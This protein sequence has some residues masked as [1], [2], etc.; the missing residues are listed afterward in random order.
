MKATF[1]PSSAHGSI[2]APPS[3][4]E[5]H[6][7]MISSALSNDMSV[8]HGIC[9]SD[10]M[11]ATLDSILAMGLTT[12]WRGDTVNINEKRETIND[13]QS[14]FDDDNKPIFPCYES[15]STLRFMIP[16]ALALFGGGAF[17]CQKRLIERGVEV[18]EEV[19][20][21]DGVTI[22][23]YDEAIVALGKL[24]GGKYTLRGDVSS[25]YISGLLFALPLL[26]CD[27]QIEVL[28]PFESK[29]YVDM[30]INVLAK[31]GVEIQREGNCFYI[32][33]GQTYKGGE[34]FVDG[35]WSN[36]AFLLALNEVGGCVDVKGLDCNSL[37]GD[38]VCKDIFEKLNER[39]PVIDLAN[40]PDLAPIA[41]VVASLKNGAKFVNT[42]RLKIKESDRA[43]VM[44]EEMGKLSIDVDVREN[45]VYVHK[46]DIKTTDTALYGHNDH[47]VV[48]A[49]SVLLSHVGGSIDGV[50]AVEKSFP[51]FFDVLKEL[52][53]NCEIDY[54]PS[55]E[56]IAKL[57]GVV[58]G[59]I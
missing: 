48:M 12:N 40:C 6:R 14:K 13:K 45:E 51:N 38:K 52:G 55:D 10:D 49:L 20:K 4:S 41:F 26:D 42:R 21:Q 31:F 47:R 37:Q 30:T 17:E 32:K 54:T 18:Y 22:D 3:K 58:G 44:A 5:A 50:E 8:I 15:G 25:Q 23:Y 11:I 57:F 59:G 28:E 34:F 56:E 46:C 1:F 2:P 24:K 29:N 16:I 36:S 43:S 19:L 53:V 33:G 7:Y 35:D 9:E 27:S 39:E